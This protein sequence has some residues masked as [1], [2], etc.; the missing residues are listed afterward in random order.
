MNFAE[1]MDSWITEKI[2]RAQTDL[3]ARVGK[4]ELRV[5]ELEEQVVNAEAVRNIANAQIDSRNN[6]LAT[7]NSLTE[8]RV[9]ELIQ[10]QL[11]NT[12]WSDMIGEEVNELIESA[13]DN[14]DSIRDEIRSLVDEQL[15]G[16]LD[17]LRIT[18]RRG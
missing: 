17:D 7:S 8:F 13:I 11:C 2:V 15:D 6:G 14:N 3:V 5:A 16:E 18:V 12:D 4:L 1:L 10:T 9:G